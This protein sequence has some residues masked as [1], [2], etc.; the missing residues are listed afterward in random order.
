MSTDSLSL[1]DLNGGDG[2][3]R[4]GKGQYLIVPKGGSKPTGFSRVTTV[5]STLGT[6]FGIVSWKATM[7]AVGA[8]L[9]PGLR[10][11]W[12][13]LIAE[14]DGDPWYGS[15][16]GKKACQK[17]VEECCTVGG[18]SDRAEIGTALHALTAL[19]DWGRTPTL[20]SEQTEAD[21]TAYVNGLV[22]AGVTIV[23]DMIEQTVVLDEYRVAGTFD[24]LVRVPGF[25]LP[26]IGDLKTGR[27]LTLSMHEIA[28]QLATYSRADSLYV[29]GEAVDGSQ[30]ERLPM[31][32]VDQ[33]HGLVMWLPAG[34]ARLELFVVDLDAGWEA[35]QQSMWVRGWRNRK[36]STPL[37]EYQ[38]D[39][40]PLLEASLAAVDDSYTQRLRDWLQGRI[41]AIGRDRKA[42]ADL[43]IRWPPGMPTL[44]RSTEHTPEDLDVI[45]QLLEDVEA[46]Y[47]IPFGES[48]PTTDAVGQLLHLFPGSSVVDELVPTKETPTS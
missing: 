45:E 2:A 10:A 1:V 34:E 3:R 4:N 19:V 25:K 22:E 42:G 46:R 44:R 48:K 35:F 6:E 5:A 14:H 7:T 33:H 9:R 26:L 24:R 23:P 47:S 43:G 31:P 18:G 15:Q 28:V 37:G 13:A 32:E 41:D 20:L 29:Q 30:D 21:L 27:D 36:V 38:P 40:V 39:L 8:M 16:A 17:L 12:E 11:R